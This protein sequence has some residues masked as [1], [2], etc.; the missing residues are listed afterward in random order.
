MLEVEFAVAV[1]DIK[2]AGRC[3]EDTVRIEARSKGDELRTDDRLSCTRA[4]SKR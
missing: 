2:V 3:R 1:E 4:T